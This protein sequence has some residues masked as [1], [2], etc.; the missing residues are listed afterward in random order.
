[1]TS[2]LFVAETGMLLVL[3]KREGDFVRTNRRIA[4]GFAKER[5]DESVARVG[6][7]TTAATADLEKVINEKN[8]TRHK[9]HRD[10][11]GNICHTR[12]GSQLQIADP[13]IVP[14]LYG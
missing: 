6:S 14:R 11:L 13:A 10:H 5:K 2:A 12:C 8:C 7:R 1:M 9:D 4:S 3:N